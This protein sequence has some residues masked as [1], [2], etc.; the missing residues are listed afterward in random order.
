MDIKQ[1]YLFKKK[2]ELSPPLVQNLYILYNRLV[3][4]TYK[5]RNY[6]YSCNSYVVYQFVQ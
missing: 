4:L 5:L 2:K 1:V 3:K 6:C